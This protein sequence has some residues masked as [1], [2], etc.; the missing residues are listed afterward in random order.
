MHFTAELER[1]RREAD[2]AG[3]KGPLNHDCYRRAAHRERLAARNA[4]FAAAGRWIASLFRRAPRGKLL[5][6]RA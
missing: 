2:A 5:T 1:H 6:G 3:R 4:A